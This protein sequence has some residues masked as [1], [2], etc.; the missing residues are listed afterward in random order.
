MVGFFNTDSGTKSRVHDGRACFKGIGLFRTREKSEFNK[1]TSEH[2]FILRILAS[3]IHQWLILLIL[4]P[5]YVTCILMMDRESCPIVPEGIHTDSINA[6][7]SDWFLHMPC[8]F[9]SFKTIRLRS[10]CCLCFGSM[11]RNSK[12]A[13][14]S[15]SFM[16][17][18]PWA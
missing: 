6:A 12:S 17:S 11:Q 5:S 8:L 15:V 10:P 4:T 16:S 2:P 13:D 18:H 3:G 14:L 7:R 1:V 9:L